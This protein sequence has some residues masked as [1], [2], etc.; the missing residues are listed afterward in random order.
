M[1]AECRCLLSEK[2]DLL[3]AVSPLV[4]LSA[5]IDVLLTVLQHS[6]DQ[7]GEPMSHGRDGFRLPS[8]NPQFCDLAGVVP[9]SC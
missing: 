1:E 3:L 5:F 6:I 2:L 9:P 8:S 7:S 4:V